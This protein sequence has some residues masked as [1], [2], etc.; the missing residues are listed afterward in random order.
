MRCSGRERCR[1]TR[2]KPR[3]MP[4]S[5]L[6]RPSASQA[7]VASFLRDGAFLGLLATLL[8]RLFDQLLGAAGEAGGAD[9]RTAVDAI[10]AVGFEGDR[11]VGP[12]FTRLARAALP[13]ALR[14]AKPLALRLSPDCQLPQPWLTRARAWG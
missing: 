9:R 13:V 7:A 4:G 12:G 6:N 11:L 14:N 8:E 2:S 3:S 1:W 5:P 10:L